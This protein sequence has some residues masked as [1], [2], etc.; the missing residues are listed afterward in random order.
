MCDMKQFW[1]NKNSFPKGPD[2]TFSKKPENLKSVL[3][4]FKPLFD[5]HKNNNKKDF[6]KTLP[7]M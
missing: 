1:T 4:Y 3:C 2:G 5:R 7:Y 6:L